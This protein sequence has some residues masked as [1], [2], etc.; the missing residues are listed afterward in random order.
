MRK[1]N[2]VNY[3][4]E[5]LIDYFRED[6]RIMTVYLFGSYGT[7]YE[8]KL[9]DIDLAILFNDDSISMMEEMGIAAEIEFKLDFDEVDLVNLNKASVIL[10]HEIISKGVK[11]FEREELYTAE[12]VEKTLKYYFDFGLVYKKFKDDYQEGLREEYCSSD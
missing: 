12:F 9:S 2:K 4:A 3:L 6:D 10:Q 7:E 1:K 5:E 8:T 11:I